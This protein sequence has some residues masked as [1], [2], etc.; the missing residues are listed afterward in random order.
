MN[1]NFQDPSFPINDSI[2]DEETWKDHYKR[3]SVNG[4]S[5]D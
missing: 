1:R 5:T 3:K 4:T 2:I